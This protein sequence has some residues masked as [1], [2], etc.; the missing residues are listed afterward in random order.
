VTKTERLVDCEFTT[1]VGSCARCGLDH[2]ALTFRLFSNP[3]GRY[4]HWSMCPEKQE[5]ILMRSVIVEDTTESQTPVLEC[6][7]ENV[8]H[9]VRVRKCFRRMGIAT[10]G[11]L[12]QKSSFEISSIKNVGFTTVSIIKKKLES[13][14]L[15]LREDEILPVDDLVLEHRV[16]L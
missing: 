14:G 16:E 2:E 15:S 4:T 11:E 8:F 7:L 9:Q 10:V 12:I 1:N 13:M 5:P 6:K 3:C